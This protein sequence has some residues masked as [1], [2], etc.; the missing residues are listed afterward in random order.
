[1]TA[2]AGSGA[3][4][5]RELKELLVS[6]P[7]ARP[8]D[9]A[10]LASPGTAARAARAAA[11]TEWEAA[12]AAPPA[13]SVE[14]ADPTA[15]EVAA[16]AVAARRGA[17]PSQAAAVRAAATRRVTVIQGP[18]GTGK[19]FTTSCLIETLVRLRRQAGDAGGGDAE[20]KILA[21]ANSHVAA[22]NLMGALLR[23]GGLRVLRLG[24]AAT[25]GAAVR[26]HTIEAVRSMTPDGRLSLPPSLPPSLPLSLS[27]SL[28][29]S[30]AFSLSA[31]LFPPLL[32]SSSVLVQPRS[33]SA[34]RGLP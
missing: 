16:A 26:G 1:V 11:S 15:V 20:D 4:M 18:P 3:G 17:N 14:A 25:V 23:L 7:A 5:A 8:R 29:L 30:L 28:S 31:C 6:S 21:A 19:T 10:R 34:G 22:D 24:R 9:V 13:D 32:P 12:A 2:A 33:P 27:L